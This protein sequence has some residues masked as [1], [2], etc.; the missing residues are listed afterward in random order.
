M[1]ALD[2]GD[3]LASID[4]LEAYL[5]MP[6]HPVHRKY[7]RFSYGSKHYQY[8]AVL[9]GLSAATRVFA[10]LLVVL[11]ANLR[12]QRICIFLYLNDILI[13]ASSFSQASDDVYNTMF[14]LRHHGFVVNW[15]KSYLTLCQRLIHLGLLM[16]T[17]SYQLFLSPS[18]RELPSV[19]LVTLASL[20]GLMV[21][22]KDV[23]PWSQF[24]LRLLQSFL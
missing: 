10:K 15:T 7:L 20:L 5:H 21:S 19:N 11:V 8:R 23:I 24:H 2:Q 4:L 17:K 1:A 14:S 22:C 6:I 18:S 12:L 13:A 9:F 3:F 16:D